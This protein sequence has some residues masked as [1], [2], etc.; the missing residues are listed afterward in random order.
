MK[1]TISIILSIMLLM[2]T[3]IS[4]Y[5]NDDIKVTLDGKQ[6][7]FDVAP[8]IINN[9]TMVPLRAIFE[10]LGATVEWDNDTQTVTA[11]KSEITIKLT[12]ND[13]KMYVNNN[14]IALDSPACLVNGR[15]LVPVRA[16]SEAFGVS[17]KWDDLAQTVLMSTSGEFV[18]PIVTMYATDGRT[19]SVKE[20][21]IN[22]YKAVGWYSEPVVI[23]YSY[24]GNMMVIPQ[25]QIET[26]RSQGW[27]T[28]PEEAKYTY[29]NGTGIPTFESVTGI[30]L[31][32]T[33]VIDGTHCYYYNGEATLKVTDYLTVLESM[34]FKWSIEPQ[35]ETRITN[36]TVNKVAVK[37]YY[38]V[39]RFG[40]S[41]YERFS[42]VRYSYS[43]K[44]YPGQVSILLI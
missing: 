37:Y 34:G 6:L 24:G 41:G 44:V 38:S 7:T 14:V 17:V 18:E 32:E 29:Y 11:K 43:S 16:V 42:I 5:A 9:R 22:A 25:S 33:K 20:S 28:N 39:Y 26:Y 15:T 30:S 13:P 19:I 4:V 3:I 40:N 35:Y 21:E 1:K 12:I 31:N 36:G 8:Q 23:V 10:A 27:Y 2:S